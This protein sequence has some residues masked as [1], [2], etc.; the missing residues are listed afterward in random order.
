MDTINEI[1]NFFK[2]YPSQ[3]INKGHILLRPGEIPHYAYYLLTGTVN[4]YDIASSGNEIIVNTYRERDILPLTNVFDMSESHFFLEAETSL[5]TLVAPIEDLNH[6]IATNPKVSLH[7]LA[8]VLREN[9]YLFRHLSHQM[10]GA[11][12]SQILFEIINNARKFGT[13]LP[14]GDTKLTLNESSLAKR[15]GLSRETV[16][17]NLKELKQQGIVRSGSSGIIVT[18]LEHLDDQLVL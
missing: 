7:L 3:K 4:L 8:K 14:S 2:S 6:F 10:G 15:V 13:R 5:T 9:D 12:I 1:I 16:N 17:R 18:N 11:A